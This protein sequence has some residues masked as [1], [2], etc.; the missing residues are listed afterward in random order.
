ML[1]TTLA[2]DVAEL[3]KRISTAAQLSGTRLRYTHATCSSDPWACEAYTYTARMKSCYQSH[4]NP[5]YFLTTSTA[6]PTLST[7][8]TG[9]FLSLCSSVIARAAH[10]PSTHRI[11]VPTALHGHCHQ[12]STVGRGVCDCVHRIIALLVSGMGST[13][14]SSIDSHGFG[15]TG[16]ESVYHEECIYTAFPHCNRASCDSSLCIAVCPPTPA[17][18]HHAAP[19]SLQVSIEWIRESD[20]RVAMGLDKAPAGRCWG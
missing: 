17:C 13:H 8:V 11:Y 18:I 1:W 4:L 14:H 2:R 7:K 20:E 10:A 19:F 16:M 15:G 3:G 12:I 9:L 5:L 6:S